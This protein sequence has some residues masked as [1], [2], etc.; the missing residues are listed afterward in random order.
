[1]RAEESD[2]FAGRDVLEKNLDLVRNAVGIDGKADEDQGVFIEAPDLVQR[3]EDFIPF[4]GGK[5]RFGDFFRVARSG[6]IGDE[7][8]MH[9]PIFP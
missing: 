3:L 9:G 2:F 4:Q 8:F 5:N 1:V 7:S 6:E